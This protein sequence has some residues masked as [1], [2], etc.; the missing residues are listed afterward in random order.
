MCTCLL[1]TLLRLVLYKV[2]DLSDAVVSLELP[3]RRR[4]RRAGLRIRN[5]RVPQS[6]L[7]LGTAKVG[8]IAAIVTWSGV[9]SWCVV[10][11]LQQM[12]DQSVP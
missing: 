1:L 7:K 10:V 12:P 6:L 5:L 9:F 11:P 2:L 3:N 8:S 4:W